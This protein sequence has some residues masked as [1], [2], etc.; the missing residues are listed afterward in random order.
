MA[1]LTFKAWPSCSSTHLKIIA[2]Q[3]ASSG[4]IHYLGKQTALILSSNTNFKLL[5]ILLRPTTPPSFELQCRKWPSFLLRSPKTM[6]LCQWNVKHKHPC[7]YTSV[8]L[9]ESPPLLSTFGVVSELNYD[10]GLF[11]LEI[12][13]LRP[14]WH[15]SCSWNS[16]DVPRKV[17]ALSARRTSNK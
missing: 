3:N 16:A 17:D 14:V 2:F 7:S 15:T 6:L 1:K 5:S 9:L 13:L 12:Y 4:N 10:D 11:P 8:C